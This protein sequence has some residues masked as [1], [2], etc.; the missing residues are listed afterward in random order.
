MPTNLVNAL[1]L[2]LGV[3]T[4]TQLIEQLK[5][6]ASDWQPAGGLT[7]SNFKPFPMWGKTGFYTT[8]PDL[9]GHIDVEMTRTLARIEVGVDINNP[10]A[11]DPALGFGHIFTI[12]S[13][14]VCN[15]NDSAYIAPNGTIK[16]KKVDIGYR[17][18]AD[19]LILTRSIYVPETDSLILG[20][21]NDTIHRPPYVILKASYYNGNPYY[22]RIDFSL[23][24]KY[25]PLLR[26][27]SYT[28]NIT[29]IRTVG[30]ETLEKAKN[31]PILPLNPN[32][33]LSGEA[34]S[35][36]RNINDIVYRDN[37]WLGCEATE[38]KAD[39][40]TTDIPVMVSTSYPGGW[41]A[42]KVSGSSDFSVNKAGDVL[43]VVCAN[44]NTT[45]QPRTAKL[46]LTAGTLTQYIN[47]TQSPGSHT[48][49][50]QRGLGIT[51]PLASANIDG[52]NR[53]AQIATVKYAY[54][55]SNPSINPS[56]TSFPDGVITIPGNSC[57]LLGNIT[58]FAYNS[59]NQALW[60]WVI[61]VVDTNIKFED[62]GNQKYY[63]GYT[64]MDRNLGHFDSYGYD[65]C[66]YY[67]WG[68]KAPITPIYPSPAPSNM[69]AAEVTKYPDSFFT[70]TAAQSF[71][72]MTAGQNNNLWTTID[73]EKG[74]WDPCP[75]GWRVP[76]AENNEASPW[77]GF[78][79]GTYMA[80]EALSFGG[81]NGIDGSKST[82][83]L[84]PV[85]G[86]SA[87]GI[88][89]YVYDA[90]AGVH[91]QAHRADAYPIRCIRD[92]KR[93]G[94]TLIWKLPS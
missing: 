56:I 12:D 9:P 52:V 89:A 41:S 74:M 50:M 22:Y 48:Y 83:F 85:W 84:R 77:N 30:Y 1:N 11:G 40:N 72:W 31:A 24:D 59:A 75:F 4:E 38:V 60:S 58:V 93:Q 67:Q 92:A 25:R 18:P 33:V 23:G 90:G 32:L 80:V 37:Y 45:G 63:N 54:R 91:R 17:F 15:V 65:S 57:N 13:V 28:F 26:N 70:A 7:S 87:R 53:S 42:E 20:A 27:Y 46:K 79:N 8:L 3:T 81:Y 29:G 62:S 21:S 47:V 76:P 82:S 35:I 6:S 34:T 5:F 66:L 88:D 86:A 73:G 36:T 94:A 64:F 68:R 49:V 78:V 14:Y 61:W 2:Q 55:G 16:S 51:I 69:T 44:R 43:H 39:W 19:D 10:A 71:D